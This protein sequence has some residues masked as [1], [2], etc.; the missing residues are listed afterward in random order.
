MPVSHLGLFRAAKVGAAQAP[1]PSAARVCKAVRRET[2]SSV[3]MIRL[4]AGAGGQTTWKPLSSIRV[5]ASIRICREGVCRPPRVSPAAGVWFKKQAI[6]QVGHSEKLRECPCTPR[7]RLSGVGEV[8]ERP[9]TPPGMARL[10]GVGKCDNGHPLRGPWHAFQA[11]GKCE[12][13]RPLRQA[14]HAFQAWGIATTAIH[15]AGHGTPFRR[16]GS[17]R[18]AVHSAGHGTP[19]R[20]GELRQRPSTPRAMARLSGVGNCDNGHPL[21]GPWHAFQ[22]WGSARTAVH[23][24]GH[25]TPFRRGEVRERPS[26]P[27]AMARLS[28]AFRRGGSATTA[29]HSAGTPFRRGKCEKSVHPRCI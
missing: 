1:A 14:W 8:R 2:A 12:N 7:A 9:S 24:A 15:S 21:R 29:I 18:T 25:G 19:F 23:S 11:W 27:R 26:T 22:A 17:A 28:G 13:G 5:C 16:G 20:R 4:N 10:S 6:A 3:D